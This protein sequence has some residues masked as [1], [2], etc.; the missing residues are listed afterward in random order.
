MIWL[1]FSLW[2]S[3]PTIINTKNASIS[4]THIKLNY[5]YQTH[6]FYKKDIHLQF[7]SKLANELSISSKKI[8]IYKKN[9]YHAQKLQK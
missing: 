2:L 9:I 1:S 4:Y 7:K 3:L 6:V 8:T 5:S